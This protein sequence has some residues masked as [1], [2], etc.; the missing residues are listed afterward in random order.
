LRL[1]KPFIEDMIIS[2]PDDIKDLKNLTLI[3]GGARS[4]K[5]FLAE[6]LAASKSQSVVYLATMQ[7]FDDDH[8]TANRIASHKH[9]R[10]GNWQTIEE[11]LEL[12]QAVLKLPDTTGACLV[13][14]LS[15]WVSNVLLGVPQNEIGFGTV[16]SILSDGVANL[17]AAVRQRAA[18]QFVFVTNEV[19]LGIVPENRLGRVFRDSLGIVNQSVAKA[20]NEVWLISVGQPYRLKP[21]LSPLPPGLSP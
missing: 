3:T 5:S 2:N 1:G 8:E 20:A 11:P 16:D 10:P 12:A 13:D 4:G 15:L 18:V 17:C 7:R 6:K 21:P 9:R 14:C 19:G